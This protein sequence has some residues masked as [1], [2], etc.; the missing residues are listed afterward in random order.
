MMMLDK[1]TSFAF[2]WGSGAWGVSVKK[3]ILK[4]FKHGNEL[5][6]FNTEPGQ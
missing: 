4:E 1:R 5:E 3:K 6:G 2:G